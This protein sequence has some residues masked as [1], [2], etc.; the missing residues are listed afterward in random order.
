[1][2]IKKGRGKLTYVNN[3]SADE[4]LFYS[5]RSGG[6]DKY[7]ILKSRIGIFAN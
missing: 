3:C 5:V 6:S 4:L 2:K 1:V 7:C